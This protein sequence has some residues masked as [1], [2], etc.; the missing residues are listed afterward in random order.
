MNKVWFL[1]LF[2]NELR[3]SLSYGVLGRFMENNKDF[4]EFVS[5]SDYS[6]K[7]FKGVDSSPYG[8]GPGM[9]M[10][11]DVLTRA[12]T[13]GVFSH[14]NHR[15]ELRVIYPSPRGKRWSNI[16]AR[17]FAKDSRDVVFICGR[18]EGIDE[19]FI[20]KY[21]DEEFSIGDYILSGG[22]Q[23][24]SIMIDSSLRF[25]S[26]YL[27]NGDS[28]TNDSF[29]EKLLD[30]PKYTRPS[31]FEG[32]RVPGVLLSGNHKQINEFNSMERFN[33][34]KLYRPDLLDLDDL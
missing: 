27:G 5:I 4:F 33:Q 18:Y 30:S 29:E 19:R 3:Q 2:P 1:T 14:Y 11:A 15:N 22:E 8:G 16:E 32:M 9:V 21:V 25:V 28:A 6:P 23:A 26:E 7:G 10:R 34:T 20:Q 31:D 24:A 17:A 12:L 13:Q